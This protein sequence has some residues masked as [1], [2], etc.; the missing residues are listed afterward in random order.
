MADLLR[1]R[2]RERRAHSRADIRELMSGNLCR[3]GAYTNIA[4]AIEDVMGQ[5]RNGAREA[6]EITT[7]VWEAF[8]FSASAALRLLHCEGEVAPH[9]KSQGA[10]RGCPGP[11]LTVARQITEPQVARDDG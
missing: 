4:D 11:F 2:P 7:A 9:R 1:H 6:A 8:L 3:C 5:G 10:D